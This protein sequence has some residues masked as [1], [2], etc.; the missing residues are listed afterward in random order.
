VTI[1]R[2]GR[3]VTAFSPLLIENTRYSNFASAEDALMSA[4]TQARTLVDEWVR[5][6]L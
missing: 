5:A 6:A 4:H 3:P 2:S 1:S